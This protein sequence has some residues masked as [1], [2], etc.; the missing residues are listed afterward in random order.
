MRTAFNK[1]LILGDPAVIEV[2]SRLRS[3]RILRHVQQIDVVT[4]Q[5]VSAGP[6]DARSN[7]VV[8]GIRSDEQLAPESASIPSYIKIL[9]DT[10]R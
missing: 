4:K 5:V 6:G 9:D 7:G 8:Y 10:Y 1:P 2:M 3:C